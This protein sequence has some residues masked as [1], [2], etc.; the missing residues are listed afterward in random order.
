LVILLAA[1]ATISFATGD[2]RAGTVMVLMVI[3][4]V[5]LRFV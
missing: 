4:G 3:L 1:L 2:Y 5:G